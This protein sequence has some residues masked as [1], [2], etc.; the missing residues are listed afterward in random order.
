MTDGRTPSP[1]DVIEITPQSP[2]YGGA[3]VGRLGG[4]VVMVYGAIPGETV[5]ARVD[6]DRRDYTIATAVEVTSFSPYRTE[7]GCPY[8]NDCG[9]CDFQFVSHEGQVSIKTG[10]LKYT[11]RKIGKIDIEPDL[12]LIGKPWEY[13]QRAQ[14][15]CSGGS[16][17]FYKQGTREI[18]DIESCPVM[19]PG[20]NRVLKNVRDVGGLESITELHISLGDRPAGMVIP[21]KNSRGP[22]VRLIVKLMEA[23]LSGVTVRP[24]TGRAVTHGESRFVLD[25]GGLRYEVSTP[26]FFQ[27]NWALNN[28]LVSFIKERLGKLTRRGRMLD[29]YCGSGNFSLP[30]SDLF[31]EVV[32]VEENPHAVSD[33]K[34]NQSL[35][36]ITNCRFVHSDAESL[37]PVKELDVLVTDPPRPGLT[38]TAIGKVLKM[39]PGVIVYVSCNPATLAR[40]LN[41]FTGNGYTVESV[42]AVDFFPQTHH[43]EAVGFLRVK[44]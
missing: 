29:L 23:G 3:A 24:K 37:R 14:F 26:S 13:R 44:T 38:R 11:L 27:T 28:T 4:K 20:I 35:N 42:R 33:A 19:V 5:L 12:P 15:K 32:G 9:G 17:G 1:G 22:S 39:R 41:R 6:E 31:D 7:P 34:R 18:V 43:I 2:A 25:L 8:Y 36:N 30:L 10:I 16:I 21:A 40:D